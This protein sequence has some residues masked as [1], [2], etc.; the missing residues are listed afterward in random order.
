MVTLL[1][2]FP[3]CL[4]TSTLLLVQ[5]AAPWMHVG[6]RHD[7]SR[8]A[9]SEHS[10]G[11]G[12]HHHHAGELKNGRP[13]AQYRHGEL[14]AHDCPA[15]RFLLLSSFHLDANDQPLCEQ[16]VLLQPSASPIPALGERVGIYQSRAPPELG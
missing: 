16:V 5:W 14:A 7:H 10:Q 4:L 6:C 12:H 13:V 11:C 15:C 1:R 9:A 3:V 2:L 8:V